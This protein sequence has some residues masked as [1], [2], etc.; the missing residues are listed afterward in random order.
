MPEHASAVV[1]GVTYT[2]TG[3][4]AGG[5]NPWNQRDGGRR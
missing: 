4:C 2:F 3:P 1:D 5:R